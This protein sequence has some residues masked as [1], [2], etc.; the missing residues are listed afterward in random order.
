MQLAQQHLAD[1]AAVREPF[2]GVA[3][4]EAHPFGG[5]VVLVDDRAPPIDHLLL[6]LHRAGRGGVHER[7]QRRHV[8]APRHFVGSLSM[9]LNIVGTSCVWVIRYLSTSARYCSGSKCSMITT[10]P[11]LRMASAALAGA[12]VIQRS[13]REIS[14]ALA[15]SL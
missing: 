11:P 9:R 2:G 13:R 5:A 12:R 14:H 4:G 1:R 10:V 8:V 3:S 15:A 7:L 6:D